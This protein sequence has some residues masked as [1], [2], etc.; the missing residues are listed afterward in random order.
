MN[1]NFFCPLR[2]FLSVTSRIRIKIVW[3]EFEFFLSVTSRIRIKIVWNEFEFFFVRIRIKIVPI[4]CKFFVL[5]IFAGFC[6]C[7]LPLPFLDFYVLQYNVHRLTTHTVWG[8]HPLTVHSLTFPIVCL[9]PL[10]TH[11]FAF[12]ISIYSGR[13][14]LKS[15]QLTDDV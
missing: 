11:R 7:H 13:R 9:H 1:L 15:L 2:W 4:E 3:N 5:K 6:S 14:S 12:T 8:S 10:F